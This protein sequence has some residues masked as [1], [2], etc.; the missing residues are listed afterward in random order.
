[1]SLTVTAVSKGIWVAIASDKPKRI[2]RTGIIVAKE[3]SDN[4]VD[5]TL[6]NRLAAT[7][8]RYG[9]T[10]RLSSERIFMIDS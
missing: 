1:M 2:C 4:I 5:S 6:K 9:G 7:C 8:Q 10:K 3:K